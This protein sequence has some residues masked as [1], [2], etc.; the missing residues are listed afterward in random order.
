MYA[1]LLCSSSSNKYICT[2][3]TRATKFGRII[4]PIRKTD[5]SVFGKDWNYGFHLAILQNA[6]PPPH[7]N[8]MECFID[9]AFTQF[10]PFFICL[11]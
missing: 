8:T 5:T 11:Y 2:V 4:D 9:L 7:M 10:K 3:F 6:F 1:V